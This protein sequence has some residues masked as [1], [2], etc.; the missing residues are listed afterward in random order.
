MTGHQ[1][2]GAEPLPPV[3]VADFE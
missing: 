1:S 2:A 3:A